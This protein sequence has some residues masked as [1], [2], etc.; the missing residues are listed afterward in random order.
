MS[1]WGTQSGRFLGL[2]VPTVV[3]RTRTEWSDGLGRNAVLEGDLPEGV[4]S[5][6][7]GGGHERLRTMPVCPG[8]EGPSE[9]I[10]GALLRLCSLEG[11]SPEAVTGGFLH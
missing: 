6:I 2:G 3:M 4:A 1:T 10:A 7:L 11:D 5:F 8:A 9:K